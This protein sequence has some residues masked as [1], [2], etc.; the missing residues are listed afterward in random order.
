MN[1]EKIYS[2][3]VET[4]KDR[5][6]NPDGY[7]EKHHIW[8]KSLGGPNKKWNIVSLTAREHFIAHWLLYKITDGKDKIKMGC[9]FF[10]MCW[11]SKTGK[12]VSAME[13]E[14]ARNILS[15]SISGEN[16]HNKKAENKEKISNTLKRKYKN[17]EIISP[18]I[19]K[20]PWNKGLKMPE[21]S[22][23]NHPMYGKKHTEETRLKI[24]NSLKGK[25]SWNKGKSWGEETRKKISESG[26][27]GV[28]WNKGKPFEKITCEKCGKKVSPPMYKR[29]HGDNCGKNISRYIIYD[30]QGNKYITK[31]GIVEFCKK[32]NLTA[33]N[34][35]SILKGKRKHHKGWTI[36]EV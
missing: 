12:R 6:L 28:P 24:S 14:I 22:G 5:D 11:G 23:N 27:G 36:E 31:E 20:N 2:M 9:A 34:M 19:G 32:H 21:I 8:P 7:Y 35:L 33:S 26:K 15:K 29:W 25:S 17:G 13:Y 4:R 16:N 1:Y 10:R 18:L 3:L 30:P